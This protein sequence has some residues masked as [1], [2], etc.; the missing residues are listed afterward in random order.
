MSIAAR[1]AWNSVGCSRVEKTCSVCGRTFLMDATEHI[2]RAGGVNQCSYTCFR[3]A[4][5]KNPKV[6]KQRGRRLKGCL[7]TREECEKRI[8]EET[9]MLDTL[10][11]DMR[12]KCIS[13]RRY[14]IR[15]LEEI[16]IDE[17]E[18]K[19]AGHG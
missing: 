15:L 7:P 19:N 6:T 1:A 16:E 9:Q 14:W 11:G 8:R 4:Q 12:H 13:R 3:A 2:Y 18:R 10:T 5:K 17:S